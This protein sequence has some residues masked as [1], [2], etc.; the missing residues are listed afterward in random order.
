MNGKYIIALD[1][2]TTSS[3]ALIFDKKGNI[4]GISSRPFN[5]IYP[6]PGWVEH[7]PSDILQ[8]QLGAM[9]DVLRAGDVKPSEICCIGIANQRETV[10]LWDRNTGKPVSNAIVWQCRRTAPICRKLIEDGYDDIIRK[11]TGLVTDAYFSATKI[12][13]ILDNID[14]VKEKTIKGEIVAGTVDTWLLWNLTGGRVFATDYTNASRTML[15]NIRRL[16]WDADLLEIMGIP[17]TMLPKVLPSAGFFGETD[18]KFLGRRIPITGIAGD[19]QSSLFGQACFI[20]GSTKNTYGTGCFILMNTGCE[21]FESR[22]RLLTTIAWNIGGKTQYALEGS[23][24]IAGAA[25]QWIRDELG[26]IDSAEQSNMLAESVTDTDGVYIVPAF[27]GLGAPYWDMYARGTIVGI[28]RGTRKEHIVRAVLESIAYQSRDVIEAMAADSALP[29]KEI[30]A[31]GGA[32]NNN[33]LMQ[34][35]ADILG[36]SV[37][38]PKVTEITAF[39][40]ACLAGVGAGIWRDV[41]EIAEKGKAN[42]DRV[43]KPGMDNA[44]RESKYADWKRAVERSMNWERK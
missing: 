2:G 17:E 35:Q 15:F 34:F 20:P 9:E 29:L 18:E 7:K 33:F 37:K 28:T 27:T 16:E 25:I 32:S 39:G 40:A 11:K 8:S 19:Q 36:V 13:W 44:Q 30:K 10:L 24:F 4:K 31:D 1:Q 26:M 41:E 23:I 21:P 5:Q 14:G 12:K 42:V 6:M 3:R 38:R 22:N 43:F